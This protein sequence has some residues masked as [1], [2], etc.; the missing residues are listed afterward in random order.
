M[1]QVVKTNFDEVKLLVPDV[2][3][4]QRGF[5]KEIY[6]LKRH[7]DNG[8]F[9]HWA[10]DAISYTEHANTIRGLHW[11]PNMYK[12]VTV[13]SGK[14]FDVV[15]DIRKESET[16][17]DWQGFYLSAS[18]HKQLLVP[19]GFAHG[20]LS[21]TDNVVFHYKMSEHHNPGSEKSLYY[22]SEEVNVNWPL[23]G[24][25]VILSDKDR[26]AMRTL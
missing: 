6:H 1:M 5:F 13:L 18:N 17:L 16:Y 26:N 19:P 11:Q 14:V 25:N 2:F 20:F 9:N 24:N 10:Q 23:L 15:V 3:E 4:D 21:L 22:A 12:L 8:I 7:I